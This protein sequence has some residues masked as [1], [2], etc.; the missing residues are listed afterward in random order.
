M[1][2]TTNGLPPG[3]VRP[4]CTRCLGTGH[5]PEATIPEAWLPVYEK[6]QALGREREQWRYARGPSGSAHR[7]TI[8]RKIRTVVEDAED[9]GMTQEEIATALGIGRMALYNI[10]T[11]QAGGE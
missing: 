10:L 2:V 9:A 6:L 11:H 1:T 3:K 4:P 5:E 8:Y 7:A